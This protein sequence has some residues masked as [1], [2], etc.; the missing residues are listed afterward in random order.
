MTEAKA[1]GVEHSGDVAG[2]SVPEQT[3]ASGNEGEGLS[4]RTG[5]G[6]IDVVQ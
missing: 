6:T 3:I 2:T 4:Y 5:N 1:I